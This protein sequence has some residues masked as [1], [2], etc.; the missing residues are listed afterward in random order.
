[1]TLHELGVKHR[2]DKA[3]HGY[4]NT[5]EMYFDRINI[6][7][8]DVLEIGVRTG[9][10]LRMWSEHWPYNNIDGVDINPD[11][12]KHST[13]RISVFIGN[14]TDREFLDTL[15]SSYDLIIDDGSHI[16]K[17]TV[18]TFDYLFPRLNKGG[19]YILEDMQCSY[20]NLDHIDAKN[21]WSG[22]DLVPDLPLQDRKTIDDLVGRLSHHVDAG[23]IDSIHIHKGFIVIKK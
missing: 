16:N 17:W 11:C 12:L 6:D 13:E 8:L 15:R 2:T 22:M 18:E 20:Q 23:K 4:L 19:I 21:K 1:M 10:S 7:I 5:Y 14:Q 9:A 3:T